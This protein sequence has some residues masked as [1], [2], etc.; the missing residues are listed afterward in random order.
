MSPNPEFRHKTVEI[1]HKRGFCS[2]ECF[3]NFRVMLFF[4][5]SPLSRGGLFTCG[6]CSRSARVSPLSRFGMTADLSERRTI[7]PSTKCEEP[8]S[9]RGNHSIKDEKPMAAEAEEEYG[10]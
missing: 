4:G 5:S 10:N 7:I 8:P 2:N 6:E 1:R 3:V 9:E